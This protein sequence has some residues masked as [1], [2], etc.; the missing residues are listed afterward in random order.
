MTPS[1]CG[2]DEISEPQ[3]LCQL[4]VLIIAQPI[5]MQGFKFVVQSS[6]EKKKTSSTQTS[7]PNQELWNQFMTVN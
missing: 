3:T 2:M 7:S 1:S 6:E 4:F 5:Q